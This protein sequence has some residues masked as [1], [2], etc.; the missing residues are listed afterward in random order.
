MSDAFSEFSSPSTWATITRQPFG[1]TAAGAE[2]ELFTLTNAQG[3]QVE[4]TN[5]GATMVK[6]LVPDRGKQLGDV[7]LGF[8]TLTDYEA[9]SSYFGAVVGRCGNRIADGRF[10]LD[11][12]AY[13]LPTN[14]ESGGKPCH[15]HGGPLGFDRRVW[16]A[17]PKAERETASLVLTLLSPDGEMGYPGNVTAKVTYRLGSANQL[18]VIYE[19]ETDAP[20]LFN[21]TQHSYFNLAGAGQGTIEGQILQLPGSQI[22]ATD[23]GQ[24]PTGEK[25][26]VVGT[27]FD[28]VSPYPL[29]SRIE[30]PH[31]QLAIGHGYDHCWV[32]DDTS[33]LLKL[34]AKVMDPMSGRLME[35]WTTEPGVQLYTGTWIPEGT[36]GKGGERYGSR[37]GFCLETQHFPD[38]PNH[39]EFPSI[40]LRP[41]IPF[42]S[43]TEFRFSTI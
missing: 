22:L 20:T 7:V 6:C 26:S 3:M 2:A 32:F 9:G 13:E 42:R 18:E 38:S 4:I 10:T 33:E 15:L 12:V 27:P 17:E 29:G 36:K 43:V 11:E 5:Y 8:D 37:G 40:E 31:P 39:S 24:I 14:S 25:M 1:Q 41:G 19:G 35:V 34:G 21:L 28:F 16:T 30:E 23:E